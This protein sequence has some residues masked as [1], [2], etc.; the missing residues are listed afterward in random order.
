[1][2]TVVQAGTHGMQL[3]RPRNC[4]HGMLLLH[5]QCTVHLADSATDFPTDSATRHTQ[6]NKASFDAATVAPA[7]TSTAAALH[8]LCQP[9]S[10]R[11]RW[12]RAWLNLAAELRSSVQDAS[13]CHDACRCANTWR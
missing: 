6:L 13:L 2:T 5:V 1:M 3:H 8:S 7:T 11:N 9:G 10:N 12:Q 4:T